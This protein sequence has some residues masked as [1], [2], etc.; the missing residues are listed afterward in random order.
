MYHLNILK[1]LLLPAILFITFFEPAYNIAQSR[2]AGEIELRFKNEHRSASL[3]AFVENKV[4]YISLKSLADILNLKFFINPHKR[5]LVVK[6]GLKS[7]KVTGSNPFIAVDDR[8]YQMPLSVID[9]GDDFYVPVAIFIR[10]VGDVFPADIEFDIFNKILFVNRLNYNITGIDLET[11]DNGTLIHIYS[12]NEFKETDISISDNHGWLYVT[13]FGGKLDT[14]QLASDRQQGIIKKIVP[15]QFE[16]SAQITFQM[17]KKIV[18]KNIYIK[19]GEIVVSVRYK[20]DAADLLDMSSENNREKWLIDC[21]IIDPGHGGRHPGAIGS[22]GTKE[23]DI[24]LDISKLLKDMLEEKLDVKVLLTR[25]DDS[26]VGLKERTKFANVER[27][28]LFISI[29][30]NGVENRQIR[31]YSTW[32][33]GRSK[34]EQA[35]KVAERE[36]SVME[37]E[38]NGSNQGDQSASYILNAIAQ[39]S[40][41]KESLDL[42]DIVNK[43]LKRKTKLPQWGKGVYQAGFI[44]LIGPSMPRILVEVA[45]ITNNYE[46]RLLRTKSFRRKI[47]I[48]LFESIK[49]F[50]EKYEKGIG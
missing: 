37:F 6:V 8:I 12:N 16:K 28:K 42:A 3:P 44:V 15:F 31:G 17:N 20:K 46:E 10:V 38:K 24:T 2:Q 11:K 25:D 23:K 7:L 1:K 32:V 22:K 27:G 50:K 13:I 29:H 19:D 21:I 40:Y 41:L 26:F 9:T 36:N 4:I 43:H 49:E 34:T 45:F 30:T 33:L 39:S 47:A 48:S 35:L 14:L 5:K 18:D